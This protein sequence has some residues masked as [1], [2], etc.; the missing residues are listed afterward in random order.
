[1]EQVLAKLGWE[2]KD[3]DF[4][5]SSR[6]PSPPLLSSPSSPPISF[7]TALAIID[8]SNAANQL[9][10]TKKSTTSTPTSFSLPPPAP[11]TLAEP[12]PEPSEGHARPQP[13]PISILNAS[14]QA[15][16][17]YNP[18]IL[19][20]LELSALVEGSMQAC[21]KI[22]PASAATS[23]L[24]LASKHELRGGI[25]LAGVMNKHVCER[26]GKG[27][28]ALLRSEIS[29]DFRRWAGLSSEDLLEI[30]KLDGLAIHFDMGTPVEV[31]YGT[32]CYV[33]LGCAVQ[34]V[35]RL[36]QHSSLTYRL[37]SP[38]KHYTYG[39]FD[40]LFSESPDR[41]CYKLSES[42]TQDVLKACGEDWGVPERKRVMGMVKAIRDGP[43]LYAQLSRL[44][45]PIALLPKP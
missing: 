25:G 23:L 33:Y 21:L 30:D 20:E 11:R 3:E 5:K 17:F 1:L 9:T 43:N 8:A 24:V 10:S 31:R 14:A 37:N 6:P 28:E 44:S 42:Q 22:M 34:L 41:G 12:H 19:S 27:V 36:R 4:P 7:E 38:S 15:L 39:Y 18:S 13:A 16:L 32:P 35:R 29:T 40:L 26:G 45:Q 2:E